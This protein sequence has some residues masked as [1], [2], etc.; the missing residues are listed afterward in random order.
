MRWRE[1][2]GTMLGTAA[3]IAWVGLGAII[4]L[5]AS[6]ILEQH[7]KTAGV[8]VLGI[9]AGF[10]V[11]GLVIF[12]LIVEQIEFWSLGY[13]VRQVSPK[14]FLRWSPGPKQ[15]VYEERAPSGQIQALPFIR[16]VLGGGYPAPCEV[17]LPRDEDWNT[18]M[19]SWSHG[20]RKDIMERMN[21]CFGG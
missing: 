14:G 13:R 18:Q 19:P 21:K 1:P 8:L 2:I 17:Y 15:C 20:R 16:V 6:S 11:G 5:A 10:A 9:A 3:L 7:A 12:W 4:A